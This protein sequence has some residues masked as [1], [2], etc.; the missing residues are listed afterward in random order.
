MNK[1]AQEG[2]PL[3]VIIAAIIV[4]V[5]L[6]LLITFFFGG[7][8]SLTVKIKELFFGGT[9]GTTETLAIQACQRYCDT[10]QLKDDPQA[11][12]INSNYCKARDDIDLNGDGVINVDEKGT[13]CKKLGIE[14]KFTKE[15]V[16]YNIAC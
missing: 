5:V 10:L 2:L 3:T 15:G 9:T 12:A 6:I 4:V 16:D 8:S 11:G 14:C 1:K 13:T 7:F